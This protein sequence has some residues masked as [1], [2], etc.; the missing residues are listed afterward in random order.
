MIL[1]FTKL[2]QF[3]MSDLLC[4]V[5]Y[6][7][8]GMVYTLIYIKRKEYLYS[9]KN[10]LYILYIVYSKLFFTVSNVLN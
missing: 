8:I 6:A 1:K 5:F 4:Y 7:R 3:K 9:F 10:Y 2:L